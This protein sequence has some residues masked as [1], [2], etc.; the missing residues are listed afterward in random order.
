MVSPI[1][2]NGSLNYVRN[3]NILLQLS[4]DI[5]TNR[6]SFPAVEIMEVV[7]FFFYFSGMKW[8]LKTDFLLPCFKLMSAKTKSIEK[9]PQNTRS[10]N[11]EL[12]NLLLY[13]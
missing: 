2:S 7:G 11:T 12:H 10:G 8:A 3:K 4:K 1:K 5:F 13:S 6:S 9:D